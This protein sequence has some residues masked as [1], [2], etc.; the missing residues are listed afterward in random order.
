MFVSPP[1]ATSKNQVLQRRPVDSANTSNGFTSSLQTIPENTM[2]STD[3]VSFQ[4]MPLSVSSSQSTTSPRRDNFVNAPPEYTDRAR[5]EI[6]KR[7][8]ASSPSRRSHHSS[9]MHSAS[10]RSSVDESGSLLSDNASSYQSS[11]F[12]TP[13]T[14]H[15]QLTN[16]SAFSDFP[17]QKLVTRISLDD[18][19]PK[20]FYDMY[21]P[22]ILLADPSNILCNGRP[23]FT[24]R[25]LLDWDLNDIR[26]LLIV[27]KSRPEWGNQLPE[28]ITVGNNMPQFR[29]QL[30]PLYSSDEAIIATLVHS[31]LYMEA[32]LDYEFKLTSA[33]YTVATAR[34]RHEHIIGRNEAIMNLSKPEWRNIIENYLLNIAVEAQCRFD[35]KQRCSEYKKWK[36]QQSNLKKPDMPPPSLIPRRN[37]TET[38]SLL[39]KALLKNFQ[40]KNPNND[41]DE[42]MMRPGTA[43]NQQGKN[44]VSLSKEEKATI[45][46]Q[47]QAQVYQ[48]LGLDWQPD[49]VS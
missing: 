30:L 4:S 27:E 25:E 28:V 26:S 6:K 49:S 2:N 42:L 45:W 40:L 3:N 14:V 33:K 32:N 43:S 8:L 35:F 10:R 37:S 5:D 31:D 15:T 11:L 23:K 38:K 29:L 24:K 48:R 9:G 16:E 20:T 13:S 34:K 21:S 7:L 22:D 17:N 39:K 18:A 1:P 47:C 41:L 44:K 19:L 36:L 12:S 46:S